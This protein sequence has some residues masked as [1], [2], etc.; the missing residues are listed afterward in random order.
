M[1]KARD[2]YPGSRDVPGGSA[3]FPWPGAE[4]ADPAP[5]A[6]SGAA[7]SAEPASSFSGPLCFLVRGGSSRIGGPHFDS[8]L[9][10]EL[11]VGAKSGD[12]EGLL[13]GG[14]KVAA[15]KSGSSIAD[16]IED[17]VLFL[18]AGLELRYYPFPKRSFL[19]PYA[20]GQIGGIYMTWTYR[21]ALDA[22]DAMISGDAVGGV[23]LAAGIGLDAIDAGAFR[24]GVSCI[25]ELHLFSPETE[26]GFTNDVFGYYGT[27]RW[28]VE[29]G[30]AWR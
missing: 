5:P 10:A 17:G 9:D 23:L 15:V 1:D 29:A 30:F 6:D 7:E 2:D 3:D 18:R 13:F 28:A 20:L 12:V 14:L 11:L 4:N 27:V 22:G 16:S 8:L 21:N 24:L 25:P 26:N 19:S